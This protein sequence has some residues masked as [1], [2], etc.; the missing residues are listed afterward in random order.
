MNPYMIIGGLL[1][2]GAVY[3]FGFASGLKWEKADRV[4]QFETALTELQDRHS[5]LITEQDQAWKEAID[6]VRLDLDGW[7]TQNQRDDAL[8]LQLIEGQDTLRRE[9][10]GIEVEIITT[11]VGTCLLS[12]DAVRLLNEATDAANRGA[13]PTG[14]ELADPGAGQT[15]GSDAGL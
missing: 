1:T 12:P 15:P 10:R 14:S 11:D 9:F 2:V 7:V 4:A 8:I 6:E 3:A 13:A 5:S